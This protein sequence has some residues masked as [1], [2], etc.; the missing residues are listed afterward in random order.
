MSASFN[1]ESSKHHSKHKRIIIF[2]VECYLQNIVDNNRIY[3][4]N[5]KKCLINLLN[6]SFAL[7]PLEQVNLGIESPKE[8]VDS[9]AELS[10]FTINTIDL[11][12]EVLKNILVMNLNKK[13][14]YLFDVYKILILN[15]ISSNKFQKISNSNESKN[16]PNG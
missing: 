1:L 14:T 15:I 12:C 10:S 4:F 7:S 5:L 8:Q 16:N 11:S 6:P 2:N 9:G 13:I 3:L